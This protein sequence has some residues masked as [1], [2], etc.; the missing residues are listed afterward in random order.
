MTRRALIIGV[1]M[2][3]FAAR[4]TAQTPGPT[5]TTDPGA[6]AFE[7]LSPGNQKIA[8][9]LVKAQTPAPG[10]APLTRDQIA[11]M[12]AHQGWG[13]ILNQLKAQGLMQ[14]KN[15]G[16]VISR[17]NHTAKTTSTP[18]IV[19]TAS[20]RSAV[21]AGGHGR[22]SK[23]AGVA[24]MDGRSTFSRSLTNPGGHGSAHGNAVSHGRGSNHGGGTAA[25]R[26]R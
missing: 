15:L 12:K 7:A 25:G 16:Q 3:A 14:D 8:D 10:S 19:T 6:N 2:L 1:S 17:Y 11:A 24:P 20:G 4:A 18:T 23:T 13:E 22:S 21:V 5:A 9:A 26:D